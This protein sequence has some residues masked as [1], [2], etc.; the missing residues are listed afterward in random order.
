MILLVC[1]LVIWILQQQEQQHS[2][3]RFGS[4]DCWSNEQD[5]NFDNDVAKL[6]SRGLDSSTL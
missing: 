2:G 6:D 5:C 4:V 1:L 3:R